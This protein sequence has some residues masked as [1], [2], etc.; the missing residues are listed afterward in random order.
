M[1][2]GWNARP[3]P[4]AS[5][6][7]D[8]AWVYGGA[9]LAAEQAVGFRA[10]YQRPG[11]QSAGA[12]AVPAGADRGQGRVGCGWPERVNTVVL[13]WTGQAVYVRLADPRCRTNAGWLD[14][15]DV[16]RR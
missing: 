13:G 5:Q 12:R 8:R 2:G 1:P 6:C 15:A 7:P 14:G 9:S 4:A 16:Q 10:D 11:C 3:G